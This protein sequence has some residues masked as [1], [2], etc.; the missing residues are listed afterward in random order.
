M[1]T[2]IQKQRVTNSGKLLQ[3]INENKQVFDFN[4]EK[5]Y[6]KLCIIITDQV[7]SVTTPTMNLSQ[8]KNACAK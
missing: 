2:P 5:A 4:H 3:S 1:H 7:I 8:H 6:I